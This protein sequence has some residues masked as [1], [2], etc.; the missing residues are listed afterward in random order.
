MKMWELGLALVAIDR[1]SGP[2]N[3]ACGNAVRGLSGLQAKAMEVARKMAEIGTK[4]GLAGNQMLRAMQTPL[5]AFAD[6]DEAF[7]NLGVALMDNLGKIP[8][9]FE[10][11]KK[12]SLELGNILPG[13]TA[14]MINAATALAENGAGLEAIVGGGLK[15]SAYLG[16][17]LKQTPAYAAEMVAKFREAYGLHENELTKMAD[18]TQRSKFAFGLNPDEIKSASAYSGAMLNTLKLTGIENAKMML[19]FQ[20]Y[21]RQRGM[22]GSSFGTN[23]SMMLSQIGQLESKLGRN[24]KVMKQVNADLDRYGINLNFFDKKGEFAGLENMFKQLEKLRSLTQEDRLLVMT[25][26]FGQEGMRPATFAMDMGVEGLHKQLATLDR[27]ADIMQ[28]IDHATKSAKNTWEAFTG[29]LT[30]FWAAVGGPAVE[31]LYPVITMLNEITG[32]PLMEWVAQNKELVKWLGMGALATGVLLVGL[33]GLGVGLSFVVRGAL[34]IITTFK[35]LWSVF[36]FGLRF[37]SFFANGLGKLA[38]VLGRILFSALMAVVPAVWSFTA[39]LLANPITWVIAGIIALAAAVYLVIRNWDKIKPWLMN[40]WARIKQIFNDGLGWFMGLGAKFMEAGSN[41]MTSLWQG[42]SSKAQAVIDKVKDI[43]GKI[44]DHFP[45]SPAKTGPLRDINK[46]RIVETIASS[47]KPD[48]LVKATSAVAA[49]GMLALAPLSSPA[50][51]AMP[52]P[53]PAFSQGAHAGAGGPGAGGGQPVIHFSP[54]ITVGGQGGPEAAD[55]VL[56]AI[57]KHLPE[58]VRMIEQAQGVK[59]RRS[60]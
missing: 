49:A 16:V 20:G 56:A 34:G 55:Q 25:K 10:E 15:A 3:Q 53:A 41:I 5:S 45:F 28:R 4:A 9:Q 24:S 43:A 51:L 12:Q 58:L 29:T 54:Q 17:I 27:Q 38:F 59:A 46:I 57:R 35:T 22:E 8:P 39:A 18:L 36:L 11:I 19:A 37:I 40:L 21:A 48:A 52:R 26:L 42:I 31:G 23:F 50:A 1:L 13:T 30:N 33:G 14:D 2:I 60:F 7:N 6:Q 32:G 44:R 47:I